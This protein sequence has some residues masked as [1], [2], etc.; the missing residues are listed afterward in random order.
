MSEERKTIFQMHFEIMD[1]I[2]IPNLLCYLR[3][4]LVPLFCFL[5]LNAVTQKDF[6]IAAAV[7]VISGVTDFLDGQIARRCNMITDLGK[8]IDPLADKL[9]QLAMLVC[10]AVRVHYM[11][12]LVGVLV[13]KEIVTAII[14]AVVIKTCNKRL[15]GA[16]W[17]GKVCTF[18]LYIIMVLMILLPNMPAEVQSVL[19][20]LCLVSLAVSFC[21]YIRMYAIMI[22]DTKKKG[23]TEFKA[24]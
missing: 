14:G 16:K 10:V 4:L 17:Y 3:I 19:F 1:L 6:V 9:M 11:A 15:N 21:M 8:V 7:V 22:I 20:V 12:I 24:Y 5:Y 2:K 23:I 18:A 13:V